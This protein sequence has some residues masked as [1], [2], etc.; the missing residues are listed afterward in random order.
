MRILLIFTIA[1]CLSSCGSKNY[2]YAMR[3]S[4]SSDYYL[5]KANVFLDKGNFKSADSCHR[6]SLKWADS[7]GYYSGKYAQSEPF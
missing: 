1:I 6:I 4:D 5:H 7:L 2:D 3:S